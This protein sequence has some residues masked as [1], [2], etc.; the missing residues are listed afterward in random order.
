[1]RS[2][3]QAADAFVANGPFVRCVSAKHCIGSSEHRDKEDWFEHCLS[4]KRVELIRVES[5]ARGHIGKF[6]AT[7]KRIREISFHPPHAFAP[8]AEFTE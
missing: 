6:H 5:C 2:K 3:Q 8:R 1:M 7:R 4:A